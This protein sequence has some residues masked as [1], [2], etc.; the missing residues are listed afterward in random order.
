[1]PPLRPAGPAGRGFAVVA[2]EVRTLATQANEA[3]THIQKAVAE[4]ESALEQSVARVTALVQTVTGF[5]QDMQQVGS[6]V[7]DTC[8][9]ADRVRSAV[10]E[11]T[12]ALE[13]QNTVIQEMVHEVGTVAESA[14]DMERS[15]QT[16]AASLEGMHELLCGRR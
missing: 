12:S 11:L 15:L 5:E 6:T 13:Q 3:S 1:M 14:Q 9:R 2:G 4:M 7:D 16:T 8:Q 10:A